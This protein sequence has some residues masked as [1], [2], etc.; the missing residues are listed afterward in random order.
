MKKLE[1]RGID[2]RASRMLSERSTIWAT[3]P[4]WHLLS[5]FVNLHKLERVQ[6]EHPNKHLSVSGGRRRSRPR[7]GNIIPPSCACK[8]K[9]A[10]QLLFSILRSSFFCHAMQWLNMLCS[11]PRRLDAPTPSVSC[12]AMQMVAV[13]ATLAIRVRQSVWSCCSARSPAHLNAEILSTA[14][15]RIRLDRSPQ[16]ILLVLFCHSD[17][18]LALPHRSGHP[19]I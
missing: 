17:H 11:M 1:M 8:C 2:P 4:N 18:Q 10:M 5:C 16:L 15:A 6:P 12:N 7:A 13:P 19:P 3:S 9:Y 14:R